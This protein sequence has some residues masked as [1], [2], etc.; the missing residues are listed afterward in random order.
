MVLTNLAIRLYMRKLLSY[1]SRSIKKFVP[2]SIHCSS[3][4]RYIDVIV[5]LFDTEVMYIHVSTLWD[6]ELKNDCNKTLYI[7]FT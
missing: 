2:K 3:S 5:E 1:R 7:T 4:F 6:K